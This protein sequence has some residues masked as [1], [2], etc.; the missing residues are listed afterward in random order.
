MNNNHKKRWEIEFNGG[1]VLLTI[2]A[3]AVVGEYTLKIIRELRG[4]K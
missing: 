3:T 4:T 2:F 1:L